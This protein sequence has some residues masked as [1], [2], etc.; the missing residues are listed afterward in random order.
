MHLLNA[1]QE[2]KIYGSAQI[3]AQFRQ[4]ARMT[5]ETEGTFLLE[6]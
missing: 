2:G 4:I 3:E 1:P 6:Q 5:K